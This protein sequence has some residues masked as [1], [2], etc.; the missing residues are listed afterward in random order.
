MANLNKTIALKIRG[1]HDEGVAG[2]AVSPG[3]AIELQADG[4]YDQMTSAQAAALKR[5]LQIAKEDGLQGKTID[6]DYA[7]DDVLFFF[8]ALPGDHVNALVKSGEDIAIGDKL[9][10]EGGGS[11]LFVEAAGT[12]TK[13]Q[14]EA[15]EAPGALAA[16]THVKCRVI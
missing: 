9:V 7:L 1:H 6:D 16:D 5:G 13:F 4:K 14:L 12:E 11:G 15:I 3:M 8:T 10:V 2:E